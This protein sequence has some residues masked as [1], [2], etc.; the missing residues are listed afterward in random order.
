V[1]PID[2]KVVYDDLMAV[3]VR[4]PT[5]ANPSAAPYI[6]RI[7]PD[8]TAPDTPRTKNRRRRIPPDWVRSVERRGSPDP[9]R[10]IHRYINHLRI[11]RLDRHHFLTL[12]VLIDHLLLIGGCEFSCLFRFSA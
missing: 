1:I 11:G 9:H 5:P 7:Q 3:P 6:K 10:V 2:E 12:F 8:R 4:V